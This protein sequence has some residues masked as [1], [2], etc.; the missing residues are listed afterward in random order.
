MK[1]GIG[2]STNGG[3]AE[4]KCQYQCETQVYQQRDCLGWFIGFGKFCLR[5]G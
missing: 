4:F 3:Y 5:F 1:Q 2:T